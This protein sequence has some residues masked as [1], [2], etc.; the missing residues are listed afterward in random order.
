MSLVPAVFPSFRTSTRHCQS[1]M[2]LLP[3]PPHSSRYS[4]SRRSP[5]VKFSPGTAPMSLSLARGA[6]A[7]FCFCCGF[8]FGGAL[9]SAFASA[10]AAR[11]TAAKPSASS[12]PGGGGRAPQRD[13]YEP[14]EVRRRLS[15][16]SK[17]G[18]TA[19]AIRCAWAQSSSN[20]RAVSL[21]AVRLA[22]SSSI[23]D[24]GTGSAF[25]VICAADDGSA[26]AA[27]DDVTM[28]RQAG[29]CTCQYCP[30]GTSR[31][32]MLPSPRLARRCGRDEVVIAGRKEPETHP[33]V[34]S[35]R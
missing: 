12:G 18:S 31:R 9:S 17:A 5:S 35:R 28:P 34:E 1:A 23:D 13:R 16:L 32:F 11:S 19:A 15:P 29:T 22:N 3:S 20:A 4:A 2:R 27:S 30:T 25:A 7:A 33:A 26:A 21:R 6:R 10:L 14:D 8:G 24:C